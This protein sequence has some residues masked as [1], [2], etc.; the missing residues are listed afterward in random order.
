MTQPA[1][2]G[3]WLGWKSRFSHNTLYAYTL[4]LKRVLRTL[5]NHGAPH[6]DIPHVKMPVARPN[7]ATEEQLELLQNHAPPWLRLFILLAW[8]MALRFSETQRV[9]PRSYDEKTNTI[10]ILVKGGKERI[11]PVT[12]AVLDHLKPTLRGDPDRSCISILNGRPKD[13]SPGAIRTAWC[14]LCKKC[15]IEGVNPHDLRRT[16]LTNLYRKSKDLRACQQFAGHDSM[17]STL[18]Y[19]APLKEEELREY[20]KLLNFHSEVKQ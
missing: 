12:P 18:R 13:I 17:T 1:I 3:I 6:L 14:R 8:Q 4:T 9:T 15:G 5:E 20:H 11:L 7:I 16:T 2:S 19:L 10:R